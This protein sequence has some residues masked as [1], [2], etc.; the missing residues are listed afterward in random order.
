LPRG[1]PASGMVDYVESLRLA[2]YALGAVGS[3]LLFIEFFQLPSYV[4]YTES[5][6]T[7]DLD[8]SFTEVTEHTW[9]G[10]LGALCLALAF[11]MLFLATFLA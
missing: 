6:E 4:S 7:Y 8:V 11:A 10:R 3:L 9:F 5:Y 1:R 2:G